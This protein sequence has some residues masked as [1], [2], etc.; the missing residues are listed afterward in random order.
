[1]IVPRKGKSRRLW[2]FRILKWTAIIIVGFYALIASQL[3]LLRWI[4]PWFTGV[5]MQRR[6]ESWFAKGKYEKRRHQVPLSQISKDLQHAVVAS[7]DTRYYKHHGIDWKV[8]EELI[9]DDLIEDGK[10]GRGGS[11]ITQQL[12]K[13]L[14]ATTHRSL[15]RKGLEF[16]VAPLAEAI[17]SKDR[18]LELYLNNIEWGPGVFGAEA[19]AQYHYRVPAS[20]LTREQAARLAA[21]IPSPRKRRPQ[22]MNQSAEIIMARMQQMGW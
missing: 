20:K 22:R 9:E 16:A 2:T 1:M 19:A 4:N 15:I 13:N 10:L 5:Q 6:V 3:F 11:T 14:Y 18:I 17:L 8:V 7:E 12:L 21:C